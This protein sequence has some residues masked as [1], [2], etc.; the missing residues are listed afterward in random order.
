MLEKTTERQV[1]L[2]VESIGGMMVKQTW[3]RGAPDRLVLLPNGRHLFVEFKAPG[4]KPSRLQKEWI[5][6]LNLMG[7]PATWC[8]SY[9]DAVGAI[10]RIAALPDPL[11]PA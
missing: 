9:Q 1:R 6:R 2:Y 3:R 10:S 11:P 7:H 4:R 8:D 5:S